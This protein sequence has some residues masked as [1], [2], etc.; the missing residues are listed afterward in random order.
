MMRR[1][2]FTLVEL[3]IAVVIIGILAAVA[4]PKFGNTK[5]KANL[6]AMKSDLHNL[7]TAQESYYYSHSAYSSSLSALNF[8]PSQGVQITTL[9]AVA[10][11]KGWS[12][13]AE[14]PLAAQM[15]CAVFVGTASPPNGAAVSE[16][17]IG[18][19]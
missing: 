4:V 12:A 15:T 18:C 13:V 5:A 9:T 16:G 3:L 10:G 2:G 11:G 6:A 1:H 7:I 19:Q 14:H 8:T 17:I